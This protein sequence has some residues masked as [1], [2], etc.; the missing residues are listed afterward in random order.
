M[1][2]IRTALL[3]YAN[4]LRIFHIAI[5]LLYSYLFWINTGIYICLLFSLATIKYK[6][7]STCSVT[8]NHVVYM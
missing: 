1:A 8:I 2:I 5:C 6:M 4:P 3:T 7:Q